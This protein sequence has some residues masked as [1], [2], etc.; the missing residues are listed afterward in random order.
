MDSTTL[1]FLVVGGIGV[2]LL[3]IALVVGELG[4]FG[5]PDA[6][7]PFS[8]PAIAAFIGGAGFVGAIPAA[9]L[10]TS[11]PDG[12]RILI[13]LAI[14]LAGAIP[15]AWGAIRL[16]AALVHMSTDR[17]LTESDVLGATGTVITA[18]PRSGFG[19][20]RVHLA[21]QHLKY[22]AKSATPLPAGTP[23]FVTA[24][25]S[26]TSVEVV[27]TADPGPT[28]ATGPDPDPAHADRPDPDP[29]HADRPDQ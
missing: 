11:I 1:T 9:L 12:W 26:P 4:D 6:D 10:P 7:G 17:T 5:H 24:S 15:I 23:I 21:G 19:E 22:F 2:A 25:T 29:A 13:S 3:V 18:I 27:S 28:S 8:L 14:G 20:V 16:S